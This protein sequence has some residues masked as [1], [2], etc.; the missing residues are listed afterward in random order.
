MTAEQR[1]IAPNGDAWPDPAETEARVAALE[2]QLGQSLPQPYRAFLVAHDGGAPWPLI[3]DDPRDPEDPFRFLD[4]FN[5]TAH[6]ARMI[7]GTVFS[8]GE[9]RGFVPVAEDPGGLSVLLSLRDADRG[10]VFLWDQSSAPWGG[11]DN[12]ETHLVPVAPDFA[13]FVEALY[14]TPDRMGWDHWAIPIRQRLQ[15]P[16]VLTG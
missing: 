2:A 4:R 14:E 13:A 15:R 3:F 10:A 8:G 16:L 1:I 9:P 6:I 12:N 11:Q 7:S 5:S